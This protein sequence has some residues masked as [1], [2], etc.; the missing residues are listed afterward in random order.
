MPGRAAYSP[1]FSIRS[2]P[3]IRIRA[4]TAV[5]S[6]ISV[7]M[8]PVTSPRKTS[9]PAWNSP[10]NH[11]APLARAPITPVGSSTVGCSEARVMLVA[12]RMDG[13]VTPRRGDLVVRP[14]FVDACPA[15]VVIGGA[16]ARF[17][18][19]RGGLGFRPGSPRGVVLHAHERVSSLLEQEC[20]LSGG[21]ALLPGKLGDAAVP[22]D[23]VE[24]QV[25]QGGEGTGAGEGGEAA[26]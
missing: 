17:G 7:G 18:A 12:A 19:P 11:S 1:I 26:Q 13:M 22:A 14:E 2:G 10:M 4:L 3:I 9:P 15:S 23:R 16:S 21:L 24:L 5:R 8:I 25:E 20:R 6:T